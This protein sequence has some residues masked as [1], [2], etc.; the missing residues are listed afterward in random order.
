MSW[1]IFIQD[2]PDVT[3]MD[4]VP[5]DHIPGPIGDRASLEQAIREV[6]PHADSQD[7]WMF[8]RG[9]GVDMSLQFH[10]GQDKQVRYILVHVHEGENSAAQV[11]AI[12]R[13]LGLRA[14]DTATG[15][16][17]DAASLDESL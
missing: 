1:E 4:R 2:L 13:R 10:M 9:P 7:E 15:E 16:F 11:A 14:I 8:V 12:V 3:S 5:K 17:F 6:V